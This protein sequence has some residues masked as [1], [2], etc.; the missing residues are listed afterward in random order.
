MVWF[1]EIDN[2]II[3]TSLLIFFFFEK[4]TLFLFLHWSLMTMYPKCIGIWW[5]DNYA[6]YL[7]S[8][9]KTDLLFCAVISSGFI[10]VK[11]GT[12]H[13][14]NKYQRKAC[15]SQYCRIHLCRKN[16]IEFLQIAAL[17]FFLFCKFLR[18]YY[19]LLRVDIFQEF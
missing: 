19:R 11:T 17:H 16:F 10:A 5:Y 3:V 6:L 12:V 9:R 18:K 2:F 13:D 1:F 14:T 15:W 8:L 7:C 4:S